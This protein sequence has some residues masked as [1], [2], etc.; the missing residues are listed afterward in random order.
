MKQRISEAE[1]TYEEVE[2]KLQRAIETTKLLK[3][4][5]ETELSKKYKGRP[6]RIMGDINT[7]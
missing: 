3:S 6:V 7:L 4:C 5:V 2:P 1:R